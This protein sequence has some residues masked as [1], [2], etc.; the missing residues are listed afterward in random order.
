[1]DRVF[2]RL[3][4]DQQFFPA[5]SDG[6]GME[7]VK[8]LDITAQQGMIAD[9]IDQSRVS[10]GKSEDLI[11]GARAENGCFGTAHPEAVSD[12][13]ICF[14]QGQ[15]LDVISYGN[16]LPEG[17]VS[18]FL[19][20]IHEFILPHKKDVQKPDVFLFEVRQQPD[21]FEELRVPTPGPRR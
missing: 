18:V 14:I 3:S 5:L 4:G 20:D 17:P 2:G 13:G 8:L 7:G 6:M 9:D 11:D 12:I 21:F 16:S 19:Q 1:M 10:A 15:L